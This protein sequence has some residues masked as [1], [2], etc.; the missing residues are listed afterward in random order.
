MFDWLFNLYHIGDAFII[1]SLQSALN[2]YLLHN[3]V[4]LSDHPHC[5]I[6]ELYLNLDRKCSVN[7]KGKEKT[8]G[9]PKIVR[10][11]LKYLFLGVHDIQCIRPRLGVTNLH[12]AP[13]P[14][15]VGFNQRFLARS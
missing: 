14:E 9:M 13:G 4:H 12:R 11:G 3:H 7:T 15:V 1:S 8:K 6:L 10:K 5:N 2:D